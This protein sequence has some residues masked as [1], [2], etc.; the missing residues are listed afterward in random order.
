MRIRDQVA[1]ILDDEV[2]DER[3]GAQGLPD[4]G[5]S[6]QELLL[7]PV[8][9]RAVERLQEPG[10]ALKSKLSSVAPCLK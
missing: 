2:A 3:L 6:E 1:G 9:G 7:D 5:R 8:V 4:L 10:K